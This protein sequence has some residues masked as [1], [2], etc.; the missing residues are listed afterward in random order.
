MSNLPTIV[1][2]VTFTPN[3]VS[4]GITEYTALDEAMVKSIMAGANETIS[5]ML[6]EYKNYKFIKDFTVEVKEQN[7]D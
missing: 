6:E 1:V 7:G 4:P 3:Q 5:E 2:K